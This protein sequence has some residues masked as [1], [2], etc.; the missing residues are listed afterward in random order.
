MSRLPPLRARRSPS[1]RR[2]PLRNA[3]CAP[4]LCTALFRAARPLSPIWLALQRDPLPAFWS[5]LDAVPL[6]LAFWRSELTH[7]LWL[8]TLA[9][10]ALC[11]SWQA[12][13]RARAAHVGPRNELVASLA[14]SHADWRSAVLAKAED[15]V[16]SWE[17]LRAER[18]PPEEEPVLKGGKRAAVAAKKK[19]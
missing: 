14:Q 17:M 16:Q 8:L 4:A 11:I 15:F 5:R 2:Q 12:L 13:A 18:K 1:A 7:P 10:P 19:K 6:S 9:S 3:R